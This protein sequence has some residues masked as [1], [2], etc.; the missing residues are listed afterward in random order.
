MLEKLGYLRKLRGSDDTFE[1]RRIVKAIVTAD[2]LNEYS[3]RLLAS[4][5]QDGSDPADAFELA[6]D[7]GPVDEH[8]GAGQEDS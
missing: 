8:A 7:A 4:G 5:Q 6:P 2:W 1:A 3:V